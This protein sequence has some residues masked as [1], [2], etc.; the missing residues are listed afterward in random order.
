MGARP[1]GRAGSRGGSPIS[2]AVANSAGQLYAFGANYTGQLGS[3][4]NTNTAN[5]NP[6][7]ALVGL[8]G[9]TGTVVQV[10]AGDSHSLAV[11]STGQLY[12]FG[13]NNFGQLGIATN[14]GTENPNPT[15]ALVGLPGATGPVAQSA[16]GADFS[17]AVT[18]TGQLY[19]FGYNF[20]GQLGIAANVN[21]NPTPTLVELPG[22]TGPV[23][24]VAAGGPIVWW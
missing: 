19:A 3:A 17:L 15:P 9:A 21:P 6:A 23:V 20:D 18:S 12:A 5:P 14:S 11:T 4:T 16:A 22:E 10:A 7:P 13:Y 2:P 24:E 1:V 8:A